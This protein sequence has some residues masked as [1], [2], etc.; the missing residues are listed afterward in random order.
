MKV[1]SEAAR[2]RRHPYTLRVTSHKL[3]FL[4]SLALVLTACPATPV[5]M[6]TAKAITS[7][8]GTVV[9]NSSTDPLNLTTSPWKDGAGTITGTVYSP[10]LSTGFGVDVATT[11][12]AADGTFTLALPA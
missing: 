6:P 5:P 8:S 3:W 4:S 2:S 12:L 1:T 9:L 7:V 10:N 11:S